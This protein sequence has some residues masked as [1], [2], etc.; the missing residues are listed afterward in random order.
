MMN[1]QF[2][3]PA[4]LQTGCPQPGIP[5]HGIALAALIWVAA[6]AMPLMAQGLQ[7][8]GAVE[9]IVDAEIRTDR[10]TVDE[11]QSRIAAAIERSRE[12]AAEIR[13]R[14][15]VD[16][17]EIV[18]VPELAGEPSGLVGKIEQNDEAIGELRAAIEGSAIFFHAIDS[19]QVLLRD[20]VA[21]EFGDDDRIT[22]FAAAEGPRN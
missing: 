9:T 8:D 3:V 18:F 22:I 19:R 12:N 11:E 14:F 13:K 1:L 16:E 15:A 5:V 21:V 17:V 2:A 20:V 6:P 10:K 4:G 7:A